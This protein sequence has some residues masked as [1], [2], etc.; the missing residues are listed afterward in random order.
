MDV[1]Q[2][3]PP[4]G[5]W[6]DAKAPGA[7]PT[8]QLSPLDLI[9]VEKRRRDP[10]RLRPFLALQ[11]ALAVAEHRAELINLRWVRV[12]LSV[13][14]RQRRRNRRDLRFLLPT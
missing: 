13:P 5:V 4:G 3:K 11:A 2:R 12:N 7:A 14:A 6:W 1:L 8:Q 9:E 10:A